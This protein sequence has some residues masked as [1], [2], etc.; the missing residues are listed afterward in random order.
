M[1]S[2]CWTCKRKDRFEEEESVEAYLQRARAQSS[3]RAGV[4]PS[5]DKKRAVAVG[6]DVQ[7]IR[8]PE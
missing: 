3:P 1:F 7:E 4:K 2:R 8:L 6:D 5:D